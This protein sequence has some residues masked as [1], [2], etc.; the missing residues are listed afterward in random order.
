MRLLLVED[1]VVIAREL[2]LRWQARGWTVRH[3]GTLADADKAARQEVHDL[4]VLDLGLPDGDGLGWLQRLR[5]RDPAVPVLVLTARDTVGDRV[6]G[7]HTGADDYLVKP[8]AAEELDAR[9]AALTRRLGRDGSQPLR[10]GR[11]SWLAEGQALV[12]GRPMELS[13][14][15]FEVLG[16]LLRRAPR[17]VTKRALVD[18]LAERNLDVGDS[19]AEV[20][21]SRLRR[22]LLGS[23]VG[24]RT[25]RGFGYLLVLEEPAA[26]APSQEAPA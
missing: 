6:R 22:K 21:V 8:F 13:P 25:M 26:E 16:L 4:V 7:L 24:I 19:V 9:V 23:G 5:R 1:D 14:R 3:C 17:L 10:L 12:D 15:E 2:H 18:A 11:L 20:Y